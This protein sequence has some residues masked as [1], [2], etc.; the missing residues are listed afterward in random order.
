MTEISQAHIDSMRARQARREAEAAEQTR[1][2]P[3]AQNQDA[4]KATLAALRSKAAR[5]QHVRDTLAAELLRA[6][7]LSDRNLAVL[8]AQAAGDWERW[9]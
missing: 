6:P 9:N 7:G 2:S 1:L 8:A 5:E 3:V 4:A